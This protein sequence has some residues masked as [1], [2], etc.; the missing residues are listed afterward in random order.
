MPADVVIGGTTLRLARRSDGAVALRVA[1]KYLPGTSHDSL[2][3]LPAYLGA[4]EST[5]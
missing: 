3:R 2:H 4:P 1:D 5:L